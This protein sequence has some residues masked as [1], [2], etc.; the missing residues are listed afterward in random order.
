MCAEISSPD[1][2][3]DEARD[4]ESLACAVERLEHVR[5][6][7]CGLVSLLG[8]AGSGPGSSTPPAL[9]A[10]TI[11]SAPLRSLRNVV[12]LYLQKNRLVDL[13][14][15]INAETTPRLR[16]LALS[17]NALT[18]DDT[19]LVSFEGAIQKNQDGPGTPASRAGNPARA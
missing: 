6:D 14:G 3:R 1:F 4:A 13:G 9:T 8:S 7:R 5:L 12:S 11:S 17:D 18:F 2:L 10:A 16:F 19:A 15:A